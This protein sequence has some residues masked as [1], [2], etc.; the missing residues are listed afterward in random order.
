MSC[1]FQLD[2]YQIESVA[3]ILN[4]KYDGKL[5]SHTCDISATL[6]SA[7]H[8]KDANKYLLTL[9]LFV[10]PKKDHEK[11]FYPYNISIKGRAFF[12]F[13]D[14][15][16]RS[17]ANKILRLNGQ[18]ILFG[19]LRA[20]VAQITAQSVHGKFLLPTMNFMELETAAQK[21]GAVHA[22]KKQDP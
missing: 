13:K 7:P 6:T 8:I 9:E 22:T 3:V 10:R 11:E 19:L 18:S 2:D 20:Q 14:P 5:P 12:T 16:P 21:T 1:V 4:D 15:C 17:D